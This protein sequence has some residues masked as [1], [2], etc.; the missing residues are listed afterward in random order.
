MCFTKT[1]K[2]QELP[3]NG[4]VKTQAGETFLQ[5]MQLHENLNSQ[6]LSLWRISVCVAQYIGVNVGKYTMYWASGYVYPCIF[7]TIYL[8][9]YLSIYLAYVWYVYIYIR[10]HYAWET[11]ETKRSL[12]RQKNANAKNPRSFRVH[13][14]DTSVGWDTDSVLVNIVTQML[15]GMGIY[16]HLVYSFW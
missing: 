14:P 1:W 11:L 2:F 3:K 4:S 8:S 16:T 10:P 7:L 12:C 9:I 13:H 6:M 15:H 5:R